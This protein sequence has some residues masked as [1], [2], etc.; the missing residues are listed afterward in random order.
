M[1][2]GGG[3][4][5]PGDSRRMVKLTPQTQA[6]KT[7]ARTGAGEGAVMAHLLAPSVDDKLH[8]HFRLLVLHTAPPAGT[9]Q[10]I[11][12]RLQGVAAT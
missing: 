2:G 8:G 7:P 4:Y 5:C 9:L 11:Y 3:Y 12:H 1:G 6:N 10:N